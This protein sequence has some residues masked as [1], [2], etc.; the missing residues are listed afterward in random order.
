MAEKADYIINDVAGGILVE[1]IPD[2]K[3]S[4]DRQKAYA[5]KT[6]T[7]PDQNDN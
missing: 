2:D 5:E 6:V 4:N 7:K 1:T 3:S